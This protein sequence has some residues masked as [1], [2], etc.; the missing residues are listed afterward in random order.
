M[1]KFKLMLSTFC[2]AIVL[3]FASGAFTNV[4]ANDGGPQGE[5]RST[6]TTPQPPPPPPSILVIIA[7]L[8]GLM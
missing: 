8:L 4:Y 3:T 2:L 5:S 7:T 6:Q 1:K